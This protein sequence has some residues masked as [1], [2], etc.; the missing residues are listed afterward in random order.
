MYTIYTYIADLCQPL[1]DPSNGM[2]QQPSF[3]VEGSVATY[4]CNTGYEVIG[5]ATLTCQSTGA[6]SGSPPICQCKLK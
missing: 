1:T 2:V 3:I 5:A 4:S 6:W